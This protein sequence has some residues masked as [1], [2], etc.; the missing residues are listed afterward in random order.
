MD[1]EI[2][3]PWEAKFGLLHCLNEALI[4][5]SSYRPWLGYRQPCRYDNIIGPSGL[6]YNDEHQSVGATLQIHPHP[7]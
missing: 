5:L 2:Q 3:R 7:T 4:Q 1:Y 6:V